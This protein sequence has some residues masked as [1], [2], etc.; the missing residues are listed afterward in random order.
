[1]K[2]MLIMYQE[3]ALSRPTQRSDIG[4]AT[5]LQRDQGLRHTCGIWP[6]TD[7]QSEAEYQDIDK[8]MFLCTTLFRSGGY[9]RDAG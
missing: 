6:Y 2:L 8:D 5:P 1:M 7:D 3:K 9:T 4:L